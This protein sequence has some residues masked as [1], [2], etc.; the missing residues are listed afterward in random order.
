MEDLK[1]R[2]LDFMN[3]QFSCAEKGDDEKEKIVDSYLKTLPVPAPT[4]L[5]SQLNERINKLPKEANYFGNVDEIKYLMSQLSNDLSEVNKNRLKNLIDQL[6]VT[7]EQ[8]DT[9]KEA[10]ELYRD[11]LKEKSEQLKAAELVKSASGQTGN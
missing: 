1:L 4:G 9:A 11:Q 5:I 6:R 8:L 3:Y 2:L 7:E 10:I